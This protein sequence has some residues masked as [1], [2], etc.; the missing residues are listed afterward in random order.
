MAALLALALPSFGPVL[1]HHFAER[2]P[3][4]G[5]LGA[6]HVHAHEHGYGTQHDH[7]HYH[8]GTK[9]EHV[10]TT[11]IHNYDGAPASTAA[12][13]LHEAETESRLFEPGSVFHLPHYVDAP[14]TTA[15][16]APPTPPPIATL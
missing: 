5:H 15:F 3:N 11:A 10:Q 12:V 13:V 1:D 4:H 2:Q 8:E 16:A 14:L 9:A 6:L 7:V